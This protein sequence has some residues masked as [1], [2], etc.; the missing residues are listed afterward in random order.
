MRVRRIF[1]P[2]PYKSIVTV[3]NVITFL[4][5]IFIGIYVREFLLGGN[6]WVIFGSLFL[7]GFS[8]LP[9]G[10]LA[11]KLKQCTRIGK[12]IDP[13]RDRL[14]RIAILAHILYI[15]GFAI[16]QGWCGIILLLEAGIVIFHLLSTPT[17][18]AKTYFLR[19]MRQAIHVFLFGAVL[20]S[21]Y[22]KDVVF[23][24]FGINFNFS[25]ELAL[26]MM[27]ACSALALINLLYLKCFGK[28]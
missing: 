26:P 15:A 20:I 3:P 24:V 25:F 8:D 10:F 2:K 14:L 28:K 12:F 21:I 1:E 13:L 9:D 7:A 18:Q 5:I 6:R 27:A 16:L 19:K 11:R 4:G 17:Q 23:A 22:F